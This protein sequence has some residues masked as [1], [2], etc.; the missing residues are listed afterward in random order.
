MK[1]HPLAIACIVFA[2]AACE[3]RDA[4]AAPT[5]A[6]PAATGAVVSEVDHG[7]PAS[8]AAGFDAKA[9]AG[10]YGGTLP[11]ADCAGIDTTIAFTPEGGY[12]MAE[13]YQ[14]SDGSSFSTAGT[15]TVRADGKTVLLDPNQKDEHD[16]VYEVVSATEIRALGRDGT[17]AQSGLDYRLQRR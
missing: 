15:W 1:S 7:S 9:F 6:A 10:T 8:A 16:R 17:P 11:C 3:R 4:T 5:T 2:L 13:T 12:T 14:D